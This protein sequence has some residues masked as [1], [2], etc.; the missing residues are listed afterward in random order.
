MLVE[1]RELMLATTPAW[2]NHQKKG[3]NSVCET[4][5]VEMRAAI[6]QWISALPSYNGIADSILAAGELDDRF[7]LCHTPRASGDTLRCRPRSLPSRSSTAL[8]I[9]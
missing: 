5:K 4:N 1:L 3:Q 2:V 7:L 8:N 6:A 9:H